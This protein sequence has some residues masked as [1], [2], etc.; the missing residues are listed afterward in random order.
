MKWERLCEVKEAGGLGFRNLTEFNLAMLAKQA[1]RL[2]NNVNPLVTELM[3]ARYYPHTDFLGAELGSNPSYMWRSIMASQ[4]AVRSGC[5]RRIGN[6]RDT[7]IWGSPWLP[8]E[9]NGCLTSPVYGD[10]A[11]NPV[12]GLMMVDQNVWDREILNDL[13]NER[14]RN[15]ILQVPLPRHDRIDSWYWL[16]DGNGEF[17]VKSC[18]RRLRGENQGDEVGF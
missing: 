9:D 4:E 17:T 11:H 8:C 12:K 5:R 14:D 16:F 10:M 7:S 2:I 6:G 3:K 15:L 13:C 18:Y 1:W